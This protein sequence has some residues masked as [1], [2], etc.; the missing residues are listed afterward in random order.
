[1]KK[2]IK[3]IICLT[4]ILTNMPHVVLAA[5]SNDSYE[6]PEQSKSDDTD[7]KPQGGHEVSPTLDTPSNEPLNLKEESQKNVVTDG[8][9]TTLI[10]GANGF[11]DIQSALDSL[12]G[13]NHKHV[14]LR[15]DQD[16]FLPTNSEYSIPL[17]KG[18]SALTISAPDNQTSK[19]DGYG[20]AIY[21][22]GIP[23]I[24]DA[25]ITITY[26][27]KLYGASKNTSIIS[28]TSITVKEGASVEGSIYGG[29]FNGDVT[30]NVSIDIDG[31][32]SSVYGGGYAFASSAVNDSSIHADV[33]GDVMIHID[34]EQS[35][36]SKSLHGGGNAYLDSN[37]VT[38]DIQ[39]N[40]KGNIRIYLDSPMVSAPVYGG[41][42]V[43]KI[44]KDESN[45]RADVEGDITIDIG[46]DMQYKDGYRDSLYGGGEAQSFFEVV[47][48]SNSVISAQ[49]KGNITIDA[50]KDNHAVST[51]NN[52]D[53]SMFKALYGGGY[54][55]GNYSDAT[56]YGNTHVLSSRKAILDNEGLFGGGYAAVGGSAI[57]KGDTYV[58]IQQAQTKAA[59]HDNAKNVFGG[60]NGGYYA[61][62]SIEGNTTIVIGSNI[63][64]EPGGGVYGGGWLSEST[65]SG[66]ADVKGKS[67]VIVNNTSL[68]YGI[69]A[70]GKGNTTTNEASI[71]MIGDCDFLIRSTGGKIL[72]GLKIIIGDGVTETNVKTNYLYSADSEKSVIEQVK[73]MEHAS[74]S[75]K[76]NKNVM[77]FNT[78]N[79]DLAKGS[80]LTI[81]NTKEKDESISGTLSGEGTIVLQTN[82]AFIVNGGFTGNITLCAGDH[83]TSGTVLAWTPREQS[84][85]FT[86]DSDNMLIVPTDTGSWMRWNVIT[87]RSIT[88]LIHMEEGGSVSTDKNL[89]A[90]GG[91]AQIKITRNP[92]YKVSSVQV[93]H[94]ENVDKLKNDSLSLRDIRE[95][96]IVEVTFEKMDYPD[97]EESIQQIPKEE[98]NFTESHIKHILDTK[99]DYESLDEEGKKQLDEKSHDKLNKALASLPNIKVSVVGD[100]SVDNAY[101]LL[102]NMSSEEAQKLRDGE[103]TNYEFSLIVT[104]NTTTSPQEEESIQ[105]QLNDAS[106][107]LQYDVSVKK[108]IK[109]KDNEDTPQETLIS[110]LSEPIQLIFDIPEHLRNIPDHV[111]REFS[112]LH[113]HLNG[114]TYR[115]IVLPDE[116][117]VWETYTVSTDQFSKYTFVYKDTQLH[118]TYTITSAAEKGGSISPSGIQTVYEN[119]SKTFTITPDKG[120]YIKDIIVD[121]KSVGA[122]NSYT[123]TSIRDNHTI[124]AVF[125][126]EENN[127]IQ[128]ENDKEDNDK[129][130][131]NIK[132]SDIP[133]TADYTNVSLCII[134]CIISCSILYM[135]NKRWKEETK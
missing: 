68:S 95:D 91:D 69:S 128:N 5:E 78:K 74:L 23:L 100:A 50:L 47:D 121:G 112:I 12:Q 16:L 77:F 98:S 75:Q 86:L 46:G 88:T 15:I 11:S 54:A 93:N 71:Q 28:D 134:L 1:M 105:E 42:S 67:Q 124:I 122:M 38:K 31:M 55:K 24:I 66:N 70:A 21:A 99:M 45:M 97:V 20:F 30:G 110:Q 22:N 61:D 62:A 65:Q 35:V 131:P 103:Y 113:T 85:T 129:L 53:N 49:V 9:D 79:I 44:K 73:V 76:S 125:A 94:V 3:M 17:D 36:L 106:I 13:N 114:D 64:F 82:H 107:A 96:I 109:S 60:G 135:S 25:G 118:T 89:V 29:G 2:I 39:A 33:F 101:K 87:G 132:D 123:F 81:D 4:M 80:I 59:T 127:E 111:K 133:N 40:V 8:Y 52:R 27:G 32:V 43:F 41:G 108:I 84:G 83:V 102:E 120:F 18:I 90:N 37:V 63:N 14:L 56:V 58:E 104:E 130:D 57:I 116:D 6:T 117:E 126:K 26:S 48:T 34:G 19:I 72:S 115:T 51:H 92:G 7:S 119:S 10:V